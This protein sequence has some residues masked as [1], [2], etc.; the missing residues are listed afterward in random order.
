MESASG[1]ELA[2][3]IT[4]NA[5]SSSYFLG[6]IVAYSADV[7]AMYGVDRSVMAEHGLISA[8]TALAMARA[9]RWQLRSDIGLGVTGISG[10]EAVE[11][12]VPGTCFVA[13]S[14][15]GGDEVREIH[16]PGQREVIKRFFAQCALDLLRRQLNE[17]K[18]GD[19]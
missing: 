17:V 13:S 16:R 3:M 8:E 15:P 12:K 9:A 19:A 4:S 6:G 14:T 7:K 1:G 5:G 2:S 11:G 18:S 10:S